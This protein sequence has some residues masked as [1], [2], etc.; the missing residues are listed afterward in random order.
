M[1]IERGGISGADDRALFDVVFDATRTPH[2]LFDGAGASVRT[3]AAFAE[4]VAPLGS[5]PVPDVGVLGRVADELRLDTF[6]REALAGRSVAVPRTWLV[7]TLAGPGGATCATPFAVSATLTPVRDRSGRVS[8]VLATFLDETHDERIRRA[9]EVVAEN[10][11]TKESNRAKSEFLANMSHELRTPLNAI[12]G[13]A[14]LL[15]DGVVPAGSKEADEFLGDILAS[16]RHLLA[17][18]NDV[19][20]LARVEAGRME[21]HP[22]PVVLPEIVEE[23][24]RS[25]APEAEERAIQFDVDVD[26]RVRSVHVDRDRLKQVVHSYLSNAV[27]FSKDGDVVRVLA[28]PREHGMFRLDVVDA[29]DGVAAE[30]RDRLFERFHP[31]EGGPA[32]NHG[33]AGLGLALTK[34]IVEAQGGDVGMTSDPGTGSTFYAALP[35]RGLTI[36]AEESYLDVPGR[37]DPRPPVLVVDD[38]VR[39]QRLMAAALASMGYRAICRADGVGALDELDVLAPVAVVLDIAMPTMSGF[40]FLARFR[41]VPG[42]ADVPVLV[43]TVKDLTPSERAELEA[44]AQGVAPKAMAG[45]ELLLEQMRRVLPDARTTRHA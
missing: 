24:A 33:G 16:G 29:G 21:F 3:N 26:P 44:S 20:D 7:R 39:S 19:L 12:L 38:D 32:R 43:W 8:A 23:V 15:K 13:F 9:V 10:R 18:V 37:D 27:K 2:W 30:N 28:G 14:E 6:V 4:L 25:L 22:E 34:R 40:E 41:K 42:Y 45:I 36:V 35:A 31:L 11:R 1:D 5:R 17:L